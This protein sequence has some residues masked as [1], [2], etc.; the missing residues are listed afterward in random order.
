MTRMASSLTFPMTDISNGNSGKNNAKYRS[1]VK[2]A[3]I[4]SGLSSKEVRYERI[5]ATVAVAVALIELA[6][7][8]VKAIIL[9]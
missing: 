2:S 1:D 9:R 5:V 8:T 6:T 4:R 7:S 3:G